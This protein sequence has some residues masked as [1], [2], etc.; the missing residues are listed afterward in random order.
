MD[1][2][3]LVDI[4]TL[5]IAAVLVVPLFMRFGLGSVLGYLAAGVMLGPSISGRIT[6]VAEIR[7]FAEFG[8]MF[9]LFIIGIEMK[10]AR[11]WAMR[12]SVFGLGAAQVVVSGILL[13]LCAY[14]YTSNVS[15]SLVIGFALALSSTAMGIQLLSERGELNTVYGRSGFA[16]L[17]FQ[18]LSVVPLLGVLPLLVM[19]KEALNARLL[20]VGFAEVVL[21]IALVV[22]FGRYLF[23]R[24]LRLVAAS[25]TPEVFV[26]AS[27]LVVMGSAVL[28]GMAGLSMAL[29]AFL[30]GLLLSE[31]EYRHQVMVDIQPFRGLLLGLFFMAVGM[32]M[33]LHVL[34]QNVFAIIGIVLMLLLIKGVVLVVL[35]R[36]FGHEWR[37][38]LSMA[39][40]L[41][42]GGE[43]GFVLFALAAQQGL[44]AEAMLQQLVVIVAFSMMLTP[45][46]VKLT[47]RF[48]GPAKAGRRETKVEVVSPGKVVIA[49]FGRVGQR[50][51]RI[52]S[53]VKIAYVAIDR[54]ADR[55]DE[56]RAKGFNV[57]YGDTSRI[58]MLRSVGL[59]KASML[60][61]TLD[62]SR[63]TEN[64]I[65]LVRRECP[66]LEII[67]RAHDRAA[68][69]QLLQQGAN[70]VVS[71]TLEASLQLAGD[72]LVSNGLAADETQLV[73]NRFR[74]VNYGDLMPR[75]GPSTKTA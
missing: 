6:D 59:N 55:V 36:S 29:G 65:A 68:S 31:S 15:Q 11:L 10:P 33:D 13:G 58:E 64:L 4:L 22:V 18:D 25:R 30:A 46:L 75:R 21:M 14:L 24:M 73:L 19:G 12:H 47:A 67:A 51:A 16:V 35:A 54:N 7:H 48:A 41:G 39:A 42:Q 5:L 44:L 56:G 38:G 57:V 66:D 34:R 71:E 2:K 23:P 63:D 27:L 52:L 70:Q 74:E 61:T 43:F 17:L 53:E 40:L 45:F 28:V 62:D 26:A 60:V 8:V 9:L 32:S 3:L 20:L 1:H 50:V 69:L 37:N 49:G 72:V